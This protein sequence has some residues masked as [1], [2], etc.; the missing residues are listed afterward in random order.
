MFPNPF[1]ETPFCGD[2]VQCISSSGSMATHMYD[3][4]PQCQFDQTCNVARPEAA[5][6]QIFSSFQLPKSAPYVWASL[7]R[8][9]D[10]VE[11]GLKNPTGDALPY[12]GTWR[13]M[14][15]VVCLTASLIPSFE[16]LNI[17]DQHHHTGSTPS[18]QHTR[19]IPSHQ[20]GSSL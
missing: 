1:D 13:H 12:M 3:I 7:C 6:S 14:N 2:G 17:H 8:F 10:Y 19:S 11:K 9:Y 5:A 20:D 18:H 16:S 4:L 15:E